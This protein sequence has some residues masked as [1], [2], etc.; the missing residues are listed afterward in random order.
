LLLLAFM[1]LIY[2]FSYFMRIGVPGTIFDE[3]QTGLALTSTQVANLGAIFLYVYGGMQVF[4]GALIDRFGSPKVIV[5]GGALMS[6][7]AL[8]F[9]LSQGVPT[10]YFTRFLVGL[11]GSLMFLSVVKEL[12]LQFS[13]RNFSIALSSSLLAAYVGGLAATK[14]LEYFVGIYGWRASLFAVGVGCTISVATTAVLVA[15]TGAHRRPLPTMPLWPA[16]KDIAR[17]RRTYPLVASASIVWASYFLM[18][19]IIGKKFLE[20]CRGLS[21]S[22]AASCTFVMMLTSMLIAVVSGFIPRLIGERRKPIL[23]GSAVLLITAFLIT[24]AI[25]KGSNALILPCYILFGLTAVSSPICSASMKEL[26]HPDFAASSIGL[27][28]AVVY[29]L[30]SIAASA[31]GMA[32]DLYRS[33]ATVTPTAVR[34]PPAAYHA[35]FT[36]CL[37]LAVVALIA[38]FLTKETRGKNV[39]ENRKQP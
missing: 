30:V 1:D 27:M 12:D 25:I 34:Y 33:S 23:I 8:L 10:L 4:S 39:W 20:D 21:S 6:I 35:I 18:Q 29:I 32:L 36:V 5:W 28:N 26:N 31:A 7:G 24:F 9:P 37:T 3:L 11:G 19:A 38:A 14:P 13:N 2:A 16:F 22:S 17:N 15:K